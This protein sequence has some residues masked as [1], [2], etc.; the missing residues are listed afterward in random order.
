MCGRLILSIVSVYMVA[1][2]VEANPIKIS[3]LSF[4]QDGIATGTVSADGFANAELNWDSNNTPTTTPEITKTMQMYIDFDGSDESTLDR[5]AF[6]LIFSGEISPTRPAGIVFLPQG[7]TSPGWSINGS[8][9][10]GGNS[11]GSVIR[12]ITI[13]ITDVTYGTGEIDEVN[14]TEKDYFADNY[15]V[16]NGVQ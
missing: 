11:S 13:A 14:F 3:N 7:S 5:I 4:D 12:A 10:I 16:V 2:S 1:L 8:S 15:M 9:T 6:S